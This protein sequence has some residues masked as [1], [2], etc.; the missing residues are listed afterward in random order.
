MTVS[1]TTNRVSSTGNGATTAFSFPYPYRASTDLVVIVRTIATGAESVKST[2]TDYTWSGVADSG[3]GGYSSATITF[4]TAPTAAQEVHIIRNVPAVQTVDLTSGGTIVPATLEGGLDKIYEAQQYAAD[5]LDRVMRA[6]RTDAALSELPASIT[7]ANK[8]LG[9]DSNGQPTVSTNTLSQIESASLS[10]NSVTN[11]LLADMAQATVKGRAS[12]AGT[13]DPSDLTGTQVVAILPS[14]TGATSSVSGAAGLVPQPVAGDEGKWLRGDGVWAAGGGGGGGGAPT[15]ADFLVRTA[16]GSLSAERVVTDTSRVSWDWGTA[17][18]AKADIVTNSIGNTYIRQSAALSLVGRSANSTG[19]V[20]DISATAATG[21]VLRESG[22]TI[23]FGTIATAGIAD[24]AVTYAKLQNISAQYR[25]LGRTTAGA[26]DAE[27]ITTSA[28]MVSLLGSADY[29]AARTNLSLTVG[30]NVQAWDANLD[31]IAALG[32]TKG[33]ILV[34]NGSAWTTLAIGTDGH[35]LT[36]DSLEATGMKWAAGSGGGGA[37]TTVDYLVRTADAGLS[38]ERVVTDTTT[39]SWDWGTGG[40]AKANIVANSVGNTSLR[41][42]GALSVIGRSANS[43]GNVA[44]ISATAAS[45]A[46]LRESGSTLGFGTIAT[47]GITDNAVTYAK[48]QDVSA[49]YRLLGRQT[50]LAG[51]VEEVT[52]SANMFSLLG[53]ADY[54]AARTNLGLAIGTNV[55]AWDTNLDQLAGLSTTKGNL[56]AASGATW[57]VL[58]IGTD[59]QVLT[60]DSAEATGMKWASGGGG[61]GGAPTTSRYVLVGGTADTDLTN[62]RYL[63]AGSG[64]ALTDAGAGGNISVAMSAASLT[65]LTSHVGSFEL[66]GSNSGAIVK[67]T[68]ENLFGGGSTLGAA[69]ATNDRIPIQDVSASTGTKAHYVTVEELHRSVSNLTEDTIPDAAADYVLT[70]DGSAAS[71]KKVLLQNVRALE[72]FVFQIQG[73][74]VQSGV[75]IA[76][77][78]Q[79]KASLYFPTGFRITDVRAACSLNSSAFTLTT[80]VRI[81]VSEASSASVGMTGGTSCLST[82]CTMSGGSSGIGFGVISTTPAINTAANTVT[83]GQIVGI[84]C[85]SST[86]IA[87]NTATVLGWKVYVTG[88]RYGS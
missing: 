41:T 55:Q 82:S 13:G 25:I 56:I 64:I 71:A 30:T 40:Q 42:G 28:N 14:F 47:A 72:T 24:D 75:A 88:Y 32:V 53:S 49:Q 34:G 27:E 62:E 48:I 52:S 22:S 77:T 59:G 9:F 33:N 12:G 45:G 18:Q 43:T 29:A 86:A 5:A 15:D 26:G 76:T 35:L 85:S 74:T 31:Q 17:G 38:A 36:A 67:I 66:F 37:P 16:N 51:D 73:E 69:P 78:A 23:G 84:F 11:T 7:R 39:I 46:V 63:T 68:T 61:G 81:G 10:A 70:Y 4:G 20:A 80:D 21:A 58:A 79:C 65:G 6:K 3:T 1:S 57:A 50:A 2:P 60:A 19:N 87:T 8:V 54:S 83:A 44:D